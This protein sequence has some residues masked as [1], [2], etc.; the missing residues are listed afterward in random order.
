MGREGREVAARA[1]ETGHMTRA[2]RET[3]TMDVTLIV[4]E[5]IETPSLVVYALKYSSKDDL[6]CNKRP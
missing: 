3:D 6:A 1:G 4:D 5:I 2:D